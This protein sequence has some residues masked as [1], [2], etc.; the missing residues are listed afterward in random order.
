MNKSEII[1]NHYPIILKMLKLRLNKKEICNELNN[2]LNLNIDYN[3]LRVIL[4][5]LNS[6]K[7]HPEY[8]EIVPLIVPREFR[9]QVD[10]YSINFNGVMIC[11]KNND[12]KQSW[13]INEKN[14][15]WV[16]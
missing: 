3:Y 15:I 2:R 11:L 1:L 12:F 9:S 7:I 14:I 13:K 16:P 5:L 4:S 6:G 8:N 10:E